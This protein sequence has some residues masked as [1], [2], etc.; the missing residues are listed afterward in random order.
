MNIVE[1]LEKEQ[2]KE[3]VPELRP[4]DTVRVHARVVEG[5]RERVQVFDD[6][7]ERAGESRDN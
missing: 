2:L 5:T 4:G 6:V 7:G 1:E 3:G